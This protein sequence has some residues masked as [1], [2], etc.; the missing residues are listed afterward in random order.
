MN[1]KTRTHTQKEKQ[2]S[3]TANLRG[4]DA[5]ALAKRSKSCGR[6][7]RR[8]GKGPRGS[9]RGER[10]TRVVRGRR[11]L[12]LDAQKLQGL[13]RHHCGG[14][15]AGTCQQVGDQPRG[16]QREVRLPRGDGFKRGAAVTGDGARDA[17]RRG[18]KD[19]GKHQVARERGK[20]AA[21]G[22]V[23]KVELPDKLAQ[24]RQ[25]RSRRGGGSGL[26]LG[27]QTDGCVLIRTR[28]FLFSFFFLQASKS[29]NRSL[30]EL[31]PAPVLSL[32]LSSHTHH[33][34][35]YLRR[36]PS[37]PLPPCLLWPACLPDCLPAYLPL[38][39]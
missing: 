30:R 14:G 32:S 23:G 5:D 7:R 21:E 22:E 18:E 3:Q 33:T 2:H 34:S 16:R 29:C 27:L 15:G 28:N 20:D 8:R 19:S 35:L 12:R 4:R 38:R 25:R 36:S 6:G 11:E 31:V 37:P 10:R 9:G 13:G 39:S 26:S 24:A 17:R 1:P